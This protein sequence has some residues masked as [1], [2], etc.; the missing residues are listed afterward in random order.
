MIGNYQENAFGSRLFAQDLFAESATQKHA[1]G[2]V[3]ELADG[4]KFVYCKATA[5]ALAAGV[6]VSK[7]VTPQDCTIAAAD[8]A[9]NLVGEN[10]IYLT[11][12]GTP[13]LNQYKDGYLIITAGTGIGEIYKIKGNTADDN[14]ASGR[15][16]VFLYDWLKT[17]HVA[18]STTISIFENPYSDVLINPAEADGDATTG[19]R[20][21]GVTVRPVT[22]SYYFWAQTWGIA[23][24]QLDIDAAAGAEADERILIPGTTAGRLM[25]IAAGAEPDRPTYGQPFE[26]AD[27]TDAEANLVMLQIS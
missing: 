12:T 10:K 2:T 21:L 25:V 20:I 18:A 11:L 6:C 5:A 23:S 22:A 8:A 13:T 16:T 9:Q 27:L 3:R 7:A 4:R 1:L 19:E 14:P 15:V 26:T 17:T 24:V